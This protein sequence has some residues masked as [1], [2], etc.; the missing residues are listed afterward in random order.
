M[1]QFFTFSLCFLFLGLSAQESIVT[2]D[3]VYRSGQFYGK[4]VR[5]LRSMEDGLR[6][7]QKTSKGI[8]AFNYQ[9]GESLGL[10]VD[11][12]DVVDQSGNPLR[13]SSYQWAKGEQQITFETDRKSIYRHSYLAKVWVYDLASKTSK[14]VNE[15][16]VQNPQLSP[17]G[18]RIAYVQSNNVFITELATGEQTT[19][20]TDGLNNAIINGAPDWVYEEEFSFHVGLAWSPNGQHLAYYRFDESE[21]ASF[22]MDIYGQ[23][24]YPYPYTFKYPKAGDDNSQVMIKVYDRQTSQSTEVTTDLTYEYIPRMTWSPLNELIITTM[25]RHQDSLWLNAFAM[26]DDRWS[27]SLLLTETDAAYTGADHNLTFLADGRFLWTSERSGFNHLYLYSANGKR[28]KALT[29]GNYEV[30]SMYGVDAKRGHVYYQAGAVTPSQ[31]EV[32]RVRLGGGKAVKISNQPG[33]NS[34]SFSSTF[35]R[36]ILTHSDANNPSTVS[37]HDSKGK[38]LRVLEDNAKLK[39]TMAGFQRSPKTFFTMEAANGQNL[40]AWEIKPL[41]FDSSKQYPVLM[42]QYSG[43]GSQQVT[44]RFGGLNDFWYQSLAAEGYWIVC[45]DGRGTGAQGRD[46][47]KSTYLNLGKL[48]VEDQI[49]AAQTLA[50]HPNIDGG[51]IGIWGW[52]YGGFMSAN[53]L[54]R[55]ADVFSMAVAVAPV[56]NWRFYDNIY[57]ERYMRTPQ[58]N[59]DNYDAWCPLGHAD[60]LEGKFLLVHGTGD[61]NVHVQNSMR[62]AEALIQSNKDF[63]YMVYPDK[64]HGIYGGMTRIHLFTKI[65]KFIHDYL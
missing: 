53:C 56:S 10:L 13:F 30:S 39:A 31:R 32:Y 28:N 65:T 55:G 41:H 57:T 60:K 52:S 42:F 9:T 47:T 29:K 20:T 4:G 48:E 37:L 51:R 21:V 54:F 59:S 7:S 2:F 23:D 45:V 35:D 16:A 8:E 49:A 40:P 33:W 12:D 38:T 36:F 61:D 25:N 43:P 50:N 63:D 3:D 6:Y 19:V 1:R 34:A 64:N 15:Q 24:N 14:L 58:E 26:E 11:N 17:D 44:D 18:Q 62:L 46:F 5:G 22:S 27:S